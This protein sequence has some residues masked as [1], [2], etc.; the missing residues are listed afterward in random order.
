MEEPGDGASIEEFLATDR[1]EGD[2]ADMGFGY[3]N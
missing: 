3:F 2:F 1:F